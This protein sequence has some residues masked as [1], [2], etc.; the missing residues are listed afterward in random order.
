MGAPMRLSR[1][2]QLVFYHADES[3]SFSGHAFGCLA[4]HLLLLQ[5]A[6]K[7]KNR[8]GQ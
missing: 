6:V 7:E 3:L 1:T 2:W 5:L 8:G 4:I